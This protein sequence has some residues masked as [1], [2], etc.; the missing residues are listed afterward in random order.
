MGEQDPDPSDARQTVSYNVDAERIAMH[1]HMVSDRLAHRH[2]EGLSARQLEARLSLLSRLHAYADGGIFPQ[3][4]VLPYRNPVFID[5]KG[6]AC[7][8]GW[9]MI[10]S[11]HR[12]L[13]EGISHEMNLAYVLDMPGTPLWPEIATWATVHGFTADEL[14]WI[15]PAY[16]P[17]YDWLPLGGGT[18][19]TVTVARSLANG[20][21]L[22]GGDF[23]QAGTTSAEKVAI[24]NGSTFSALGAGLQGTIN[25]AVE[26]N[27]ELYVGGAQLNGWS[28][29]AKW[30]GSAWIF[31]TVFDGKYPW[32]SALHVHNGELYAAGAMSGFAGTTDFVQKLTGATWS[33]VGSAFNS[34][35]YALASHNGSLIAGGAFTGIISPALPPPVMHVAELEGNEWGQHADG[36]DANVRTLLDVNGTLYAGGDLYANIVPTFGLARIAQGAGAWEALLPNH[37]TYMTPGAGPTWIGCIT[38]HNDEIYFGGEFYIAQMVGSYGNNL[39]RFYGVAD[40]VAPM[41]IVEATVNALAVAGDQLIAGGAFEAAYPHAITLD[42]STGIGTHDR[43]RATMAPNPATDRITITSAESDLLNGSITITDLGGRTVIA[44]V[45]RGTNSITLDIGELPAGSYWIRLQGRSGNSVMPFV[46][47]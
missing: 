36:L 46:K 31:T 45:A 18:N 47:Q 10:E 27:G 9:L 26:F 1:L 28:D 2:A 16:A 30:N 11:G 12:D 8:V 21:V 20:N 3:N 25:C 6:T 7:A 5:P 41:I 42:I 34:P 35:V 33:Q 44:P 14:A 32:I 17:N 4:H 15:Q 23:T 22:L 40:A 19:G 13:A 24:W 29:L 38:A 37:P 39:A 43:T